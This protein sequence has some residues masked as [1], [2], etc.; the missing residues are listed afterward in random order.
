M[1]TLARLAPESCERAK[2][3]KLDREAFIRVNQRS[4]QPIWYMNGARSR[5]G[6]AIGQT[7]LTLLR[8]RV[9]D[10]SIV[11]NGGLEP[12]EADFFRYFPSFV[13]L[14]ASPVR[15]VP[16]SHRATSGGPGGALHGR[17]RDGRTDGPR[18][19]NP[20]HGKGVNS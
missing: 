8:L 9:T 1:L 3:V 19:R 7:E 13:P 2:L 10:P 12:W 20:R 11:G 6:G 17:R 16:G 18:G 14:P 4:A 5:V 15:A